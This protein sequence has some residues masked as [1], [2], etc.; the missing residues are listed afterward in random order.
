MR[1]F[2]I[3]ATL[4][5]A[6]IL[7]APGSALAGYTDFVVFGDSLS[8]TG[9]FFNLTGLPG[10]P[11]ANGRFTNG[12]NF[13]DVLA[14]NLSLSSLASS[15]GGLNYAVGGARTSSNSFFDT[16]PATGAA[17]SLH[18]QVSSYLG[19]H[20]S[21]AKSTTLYSVF[22]GANDVVQAMGQAA[23]YLL[24][25]DFATANSV[26]SGIISAAVASETAE[27][28]SLIGAGA[29]TI[30]IPNLPDLGLTPRANAL[31]LGGFAQQLSLSFNQGLHNS[32]QSF[33]GSGVSLVEFDVYGLFNQVVT[34][35]ATFGFTEVA[36][37]CLSTAGVCANPGKTFFW[38]DLH[39]TAAAHRILGDQ[40][41]AAVQAVPEPETWAMLLGGLGLLAFSRRRSAQGAS[42]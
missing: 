17:L 35:P 42:L 40:M 24:A 10:S 27:I 36:A 19:S 5:I 16:D 21:D 41:T 28:K 26:A 38:D 3:S 11:Y 15:S 22:I 12:Q 14:A 13:V 37:P 2:A 32:L 34:N 6:G 20:A 8:D 18:G 29:Q 31:G 7:A 33:N 25:G 4:A 9:N 39:P 30:L 23:P 1:R